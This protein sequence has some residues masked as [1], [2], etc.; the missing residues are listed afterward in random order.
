MKAYFLSRTLREKLMV[1]GLVAIA[2]AM[3]FS[4]V[5][6][7]VRVFWMEARGTSVEL[8]DQRRWLA[9]RGRIEGEAKSAIE[10]LDPSRT[11]DGPRLQSE[12]YD[13]A[14]SVGIT[15]DDSIDDMQVNPGPQFSI[16]TVR[17]VIRNADY[18]P[19]VHFYEEVSKRAPYIGIEEFSIVVNRA[20]RAQVTAS[21]RVSSVEINK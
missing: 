15:R 20:N 12:L 11:Y 17:F 14:R 1:L 13:I 9:E 4:G 7:R 16:N 8:A 6:R 21:L 10:H 3:W 2:A 5:S 19:L 18:A